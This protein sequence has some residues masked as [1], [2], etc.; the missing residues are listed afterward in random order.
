MSTEATARPASGVPV[1][2][3]RWQSLHIFY[4]A[5]PRPLLAE[6]VAPMVRNLR[7]L[8][9]LAGYYFRY[10]WLEGAHLQVHL[11]P[12]SAEDTGAVL[13]A[14]EWAVDGFLVR[15]PAQRAQSYDSM[16]SDYATRFAREYTEPERLALFPE[17]RMPI[18]VDNSVQQ[19][20]HDPGHATYG[21][22]YGTQ[23]AEWHFERSSDLVLDLLAGD[24]SELLAGPLMAITDA[25]MLHD[26]P[27]LAP[28]D[29]QVT[30]WATHCATMRERVI[31]AGRAG[32]LAFADPAAAVPALLARYAREA[33]DRLGLLRG[34]RK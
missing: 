19:R 18:Q 34:D 33:N 1:P 8:G 6:C 10:H 25:A 16:V 26:H 11:R 22:S 15:R 29:D 24:R 3:G 13:D 31:E 20:H 14:A 2:L 32:R 21:G 30:A 5:D 28:G 4:S 12:T 17:G 23:L 9:K 27:D 7:G